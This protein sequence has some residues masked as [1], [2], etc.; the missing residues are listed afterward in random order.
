MRLRHCHT[1]QK[2]DGTGLYY[3]NARYYDPSLG[4][5]VSPD[6]IVPDASRVLAYNRYMYSVGNPLKYN[7]PTGH[8]YEDS[9]DGGGEL[10]AL[11]QLR[12]CGGSV[13]CETTNVGQWL[14]KHPEYDP[15][16]DPNYGQHEGYATV[17][18]ML[19]QI[20]LDDGNQ[21]LAWTYFYA[22]HENTAAQAPVDAGLSL[23]ET[24]ATL[25]SAGMFGPF[26]RLKSPTQTFDVAKLQEQTGEMWGRAPRNS[27]IPKVQAWE[28]PL[29]EGKQGVEFYTDVA[30]D[31]GGAPGRPTWSGPRPGVRVE[32]DY[33]KI[34]CEVT[35][36][37]Q[38]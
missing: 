11:I 31:T 34:C 37:T 22:L 13:M 6:T 12:S 10:T 35:A 14:R 30:P 33:A 18:L 25:A 23:P 9:G 27:D 16:V 24:A 29:P 20:N 17:L 32:D 3:Y 7:D 38:Q 36:N 21:E 19:T 4:Q 15:F 1:N 26:F 2:A 5:F 28:G 8:V